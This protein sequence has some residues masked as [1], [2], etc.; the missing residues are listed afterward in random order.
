MSGVI[1]RRVTKADAEPLFALRLESLQSNPEAFGNTYEET[2]ANWTAESYGA[3]RIPDAESDNAI[4]CAELAGEWVGMMGF[5]RA[6][7][8]KTKHSA[9]IW[10]VYVRSTVRGQKIGKKLLSAILDHAKQCDD[11]TIVTLSVITDNQAAIKLYQSA[12]FTT[13]GT[14]PS[15]MCAGDTSYDMLWM[16]YRIL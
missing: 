9:D 6:S 13:W 15:A 12:G 3:S 14:Q 8:L 7:R 4:F 5:L 10:G 16:S 2:I 1:I 11:L